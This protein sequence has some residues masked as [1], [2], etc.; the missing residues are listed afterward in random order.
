MDHL[1]GQVGDHL[2]TH[3]ASAT[4]TVTFLPFGKAVLAS[5]RLTP[6]A[7]GPAPYRQGS[8]GRCVYLVLTFG[9]DPHAFRNG[10]QWWVQAV[11]VKDTRTRV[12][13]E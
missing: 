13:H 4:D 2:S 1:R 11:Q 7:S 6:W 9:T 5:P 12:T 8:V 10:F 3:L